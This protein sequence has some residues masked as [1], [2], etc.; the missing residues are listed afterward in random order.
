MSIKS[1]LNGVV[2]LISDEG[3]RLQWLASRHF[4]DG[5]EDEKYLRRVFRAQLG[6]DLNLE[7]PKTFNE[8][9]Q[10]LKL[11][12]RRPEYTTMVD[13]VAVKDY[14]ANII[15]KEHIIPTLG[16]WEDPDEINFDALPEKFVLKCNHN[17]GT[18]M[19]ICKDKS[20]L[21]VKKVKAGLRKGLKQ[22]YYL[23]GREWPYKNVRRKILAEQYMVDESCVNPK[24]YEA[25]NFVGKA[26]SCAEGLTDYKFYCF[27]GEPKFL[28][29]GFANI[30]N[31]K[32][33]DLLTYLN[34]DWSIAPFYRTDH[35]ELK[36][37][38]DKPS[39]YDDMLEIAT[40]LSQE[41][42]FLRVDLYNISGRIY[43]SEL[44]F[45]PGGGY[46]AFSPPQWE[47][48]LGDW[49]ILPAKN[50]SRAASQ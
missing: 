17:S 5:M 6:Y 42:P 10:W 32:K 29:I 4:Y 8:K 47:K 31:G 35:G 20:K 33:N 26:T 41:L 37:V 3:F 14:V 12:D 49:I 11:Y 40:E 45:S 34:L 22:N 23:A 24:D 18:G 27:N 9:I 48:T 28:Y 39:N 46:G 43:F 13:K 25:L 38:P 44:T 1:K 16:V 21:D 50:E 7:N 36:I 2:K 30:I 15:G 19:Y